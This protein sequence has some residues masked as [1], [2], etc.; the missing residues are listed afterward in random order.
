M[1]YDQE[2]LAG[3]PVS[4]YQPSEEVCDFTDMVRTDAA[5]GDEILN[6]SWVELNNRSVLDDDQRGRRVFNA[7]VDEEIEDESEAW[8]WIGTRSKARNK[9][10]ATHA[11]LTQGY[12]FPEFMA[13][14]DD[15]D[16]D[17]GFSEMMQDCV[18]WLGTNSNY[19]ESFLMVSMAMLYAPVAYL[20]A[21]WHDVTQTI[22]V[23]AAQGYSTKEIRD[24]VLSG[25]NAPVYSASQILITNAFEQNIQRH[26]MVMKRN[27]IEYGEAEAKYGHHEHW[28]FVQPGMKSVYNAEDG[29][30]Y[31][32]KDDDHPMLVCEEIV[33]Y[34]REDTEVAFVGGIYM[35]EANT[36]ENPMHHR[37]NRGAPKYDVVPFGYQ[38]VNE[39]FFFYKSLM[40]AQYW[41]NMLIDAQYQVAMNRAFLDTNMPLAVSGQDD[42]EGDIIFPSSITAFA[43]KETKIT[44]ILPPANLGAMFS[45]MGAVEQSMDESSVSGIAMGMLP[46]GHLSATTAAIAQQN[47]KQMITALGKNMALSVTQYG[48]LMADIVVN[49]LT[50]AEVDEIVGE[51]AR[52]TYRTLILK[53]KMIDGKAVDK[54]IMFDQTLLG[55]EMTDAEQKAEGMKM[56]EDIGYPN[57]DH[58]LIR[59]NPQ[60][61]SMMRYLCR[62][63]PESMFPK[64][65]E[66]MQ[67]IMSQLYGQLRNDPL[68]N[69]EE[70]L[71]EVLYAYFRGKSNK[72]IAK[73]Q[74]R[75]AGAPGQ[76]GAPMDVTPGGQK[77]PQTTFG[78]QTQNTAVA[79]G[80]STAGMGG[81]GR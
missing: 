62:V 12:I 20:G 68:I 26:K 39:H 41:D 56:L 22:K 72:L 4:S 61:A 44:P 19:K 15:D 58:H 63:E 28:Q 37:D 46:S 5:K 55:A 27:W 69:G 38:R 67:G 36:E 10:I 13:Q 32:I 60:L 35:G 7:F 16:E 54:K 64:N 45:A 11:L 48:S 57:H 33:M 79:N 21:E 18:E 47:A 78:A 49:H 24:E 6:R 77:P 40:N 65:E 25:F 53:N 59:V 3:A 31:D 52:V 34:R 30:F 81:V 66:Y 74:A 50:T 76:F 75:P 8:K 80:L 29:C 42:V 43:D 51:E 23:K 14:N 71:R 70:L 73:P 9:A 1:N 17:L 2:Q